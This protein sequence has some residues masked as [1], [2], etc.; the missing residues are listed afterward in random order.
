[1]SGQGRVTEK[2]HHMG[3]GMVMGIAVFV[4]LGILLCAVTGNL[5]L[6]GAGAGIGTAIGIAVGESL[7]RRKRRQ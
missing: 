3:I 4:P 5:G 7:D 2:D 6:M 1:M